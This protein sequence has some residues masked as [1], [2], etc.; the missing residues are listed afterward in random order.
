M[1]KIIRLVS[2]QLWAV[3]GNMFPLGKKENKKTRIIYAGFVIFTILMSAVSFFYAYVTGMGLKTIN[4]LELLPSLFMAL[5]SIMVLFTTIYKV[6]GTIF[7]FKDYDMVMSLPVSNSQIVASRLILLYSINIV[8]VLIIMIPMMVAYGILVQPGIQ[9]YVFSIILL[10]FIPLIPI[11]IAAFLGTALT[12]LSMRFR[13]SNIVYMVFSFLVLIAMMF[14]P[15]FLGDSKQELLEISQEINNQINNIYPLTH[16]YSNVV[17]KG[18]IISLIIFV[19]ISLFTFMVFSFVVGK[20]FK[21]INSTLMTGRYNKNNGI[22][23]TKSLKSS[24]PLIALYKKDFKRYFASA[25]YVMNTGFGVV[26]MVLGAIALPFIDVNALIGEL[27]YN[28]AIKNII[29]VFI[30]FCIATSCTTMASI[31]IEGKQIWIAKNLPVSV[32]MIFASKILVNLTVLA[33]TLLASLL[34]CYTMQLSFIDSLLIVL[35]AASFSIFVSLYGLVINLNFPNLSW[36]NETVIV[37][38]SMA[39][40]ISVFTGIGMAII[41]YFLIMVIGKIVTGLLVFI[42]ILFILSLLL[43]KRLASTGKRQFEKLL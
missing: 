43:C 35:L 39:S 16:L 38:Q 28:G 26:I 32:L 31:S 3:L 14:F 20:V 30:V 2:I 33:P 9:F 42:G 4:S 24:T 1:K 23:R 36:T 17:T 7:G 40:M 21:R 12:Y 29:P 13:Y 41:Q 8:F 15:L 6:K 34:I 11:I 5:T 19:A 22:R 37:K 18:D 10:F 27:N 25:V